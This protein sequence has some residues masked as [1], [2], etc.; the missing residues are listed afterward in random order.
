MA[1]DTRRVTNG[2][3]GTNGLWFDLTSWWRVDITCFSNRPDMC[4]ASALSCL[5]ALLLAVACVML[6]CRRCRERDKNPGEAAGALYSFLGYSCGTVGAF[7]S[8][9]LA[10]QILIGGVMAIVEV[11]HLISILIPMCLTWNTRAEKRLRMMQRRRRQNLM[12]VSLLL[13]MGGGSFLTT[14]NSLQSV[15]R[16][17]TGRRLLTDFLL[18]NTE[19]LGYIL[20]LLSLVI[21]WTSKFPALLR[22]RRGEKSSTT[23]L[24]AGVLCSL[25]G[26]LYTSAI[27]LY[28]TQVEFILRATPWLLASTG[29]A[30]LD[31]A[32]VVLFWCRKFN[33]E[34]GCSSDTENL[35]SGSSPSQH[36]A[37][38]E[39]K[40]KHPLSSL[41]FC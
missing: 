11:M 4:V 24:C 2:P 14:R 16:P 6:V 34:L 10:L 23:H 41:C 18:D 20:G 28:D 12:A 39:R 33:M 21:A 15:D 7:L 35:L 40:H 1:E 9:Q 5:S 22:A 26:A 37:R 19:V 8:N 38:R 36:G 30:A 25:A 27:L 17:L 29:C 13:V 3:S 31:L 32:V